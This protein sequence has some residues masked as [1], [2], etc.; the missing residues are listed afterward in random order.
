MET[1]TTV[2]LTRKDEFTRLKECLFFVELKIGLNIWLVIESLIWSVF[3]FTAIYSECIFIDE[4]NLFD[5][6]DETDYWYTHI[7]FGDRFYYLDQRIRSELRRL[8]SPC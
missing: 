2:E 6:F 7:I 8:S 4:E 5:F 3:F 1:V